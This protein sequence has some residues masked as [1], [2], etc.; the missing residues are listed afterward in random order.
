MINAIEE[1][2]LSEYFLMQT[3]LG[4]IL[5][6]S[7]ELFFVLGKIFLLP[8]TKI[9]LLYRLSEREDV[10]S[11]KTEN[12]FKRH[13]RIKQYLQMSG[14]NNLCTEEVEHIKNIK[15][16]AILSATQLKLKSGSEATQNIIY[17]TVSNAANQ[18]VVPALRIMGLLQC[19][20][21]VIEKNFKI[22]ISNLSKSADWNDITSVLALLKYCKDTREYNMA[23][24]YMLI[25]NTPFAPIYNEAVKEY[26]V[27]SN[28]EIKEVKLLEKAFNYSV[29][30]REV[31]D[32]KYAK[33]IYS[34]IL[35]YEEK[36]RLIISESKESVSMLAD[37]PLNL[38]KCALHE[39]DFS[40][41]QQVHLVRDDEQQKILK[42]LKNTDLVGQDI[43]QPLCLCS[44]SNYILNI[45]TEAISKIPN[46]NVA[47]INVSD[48]T[49]YDLEPTPNNILIRNINESKS[50]CFILD[51]RG[52][53]R[54][55][56]VEYVINFLK[57]AN[58]A[59]LHLNKP[60]VT[61]D[62]SNLL[63]ICVCDERNIDYFSHCC[64]VVRLKEVSNEEM[65][66]A[67]E[68]I[69]VHK[70]KLYGLTEIKLQKKHVDKLCY[71]KVET[72]EKILDYAVREHRGE[73]GKV[74]IAEA[75][76]KFNHDN[77]KPNKIGFGCEDI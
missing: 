64:E 40:V 59:K 68:H 31:Y 77:N 17:A 69:L 3:V 61:I 60:N 27:Y 36:D 52:N 12:D 57:A 32:P 66:K 53:I 29:L 16:N 33:I 43:Y 44:D 56:L 26:Q 45:Y 21:I 23:R 18:G 58:R 49:E 71:E 13:M 76:F 1:L 55:E 6:D 63:T 28:D 37:L 19:E 14:S 67:I 5:T 48:L 50:N 38:P 4:K 34:E 22:G 8:D 73:S 10:K 39:I 35:K 2:F 7:K 72:V 62:L 74:E 65:P 11:I 15:G 75:D 20:D 51:F 24:L 9:Y 47:N 46:I 54:L 41:L 25:E 70:K 42:N 30:K